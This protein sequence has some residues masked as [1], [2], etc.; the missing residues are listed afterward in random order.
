MQIIDFHNHFYPPKYLEGDYN[1]IVPGHRNINFRTE[2][3]DKA[4]VDK[5]MLTFTSPG[6][7]IES[8]IETPERAVELAFMVNDI[9]ADLINQH[10]DHFTALATLP[11][12]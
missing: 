6:S 2:V 4:G 8:H 7:H 5:Q 1:I 3:L 10:D 9:F 11:L 12:K